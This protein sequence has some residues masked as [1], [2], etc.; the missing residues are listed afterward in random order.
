MKFTIKKDKLVFVI[1]SILI[2]ILMDYVFIEYITKKW[3]YQGFT[4]IIDNSKV[5]YSYI[6]LF[7]FVNILKYYKKDKL[8]HFLVILLFFTMYMPIGVIYG[9]MN[10]NSV[11]FGMVNIV[12]LALSIFTIFMNNKFKINM[13]LDENLY[14]R[15]YIILN[16]ISIITIFGMTIQNLDNIDLRS[17]INLANVYEVR[18]SVTYYWGMNYFFSWQTKVINPYMI[19]LNHFNKRRIVKWIY[20]LFQIW[21]YMLT[22]HKMVLF[23]LILIFIIINFSTKLSNLHLFFTKGFAIIFILSS[24]EV[25]MLKNS[26]IIDYFVRRILYMPALLNF[27]Y[28]E[29]FSKYGLQFWKYSIF[30]RI[31][32]A[33]TDFD[34]APSFIIGEEYFN[35]INNNAVTGYL[36]SEFMNG[37]FIGI[38]LATIVL[39]ILFKIIDI[40]S[41]KVGVEVVLITL[42]TPLYTLWNTSLLTS[43]LTGGIIIS[44]LI[45]YQT[46]QIRST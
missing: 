29:F 39:I 21:L 20:I 45:L 38:I 25:I 23:T 9:L 11:F 33:K 19:A 43:L 34:I 7:V 6:M 24:V 44:I 46:K 14:S 15:L 32:N 10:K 18:K 8:S 35:T 41:Y 27:L 28:Y 42:L 16:I 13:S 22:G 30:G 40:L 26:Y 31:L 5:I 17:V 12:F 3:A 37:G 1:L 36:G 4:L 2:R